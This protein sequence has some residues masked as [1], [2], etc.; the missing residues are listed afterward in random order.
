MKKEKGL[1]FCECTKKDYVRCL[2]CETAI[3]KY[4]KIFRAAMQAVL[5][6]KLNLRRITG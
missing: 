5:M 4:R 6:R 3:C 1:Y 2:R